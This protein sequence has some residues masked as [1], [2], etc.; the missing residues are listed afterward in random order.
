MKFTL[1]LFVLWALSCTPF[2]VAAHFMF[3]E[4]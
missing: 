3:S 1:A 4:W 2:L